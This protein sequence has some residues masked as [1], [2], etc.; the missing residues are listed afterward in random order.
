MKFYLPYTIETAAGTAMIALGIAYILITLG[1]TGLSSTAT[2]SY[3]IAGLAIACVGLMNIVLVYD[4][5]GRTTTV[6]NAAGVILFAAEIYLNLSPLAIVGLVLFAVAS[7]SSFLV[8]ERN[9]RTRIYPY[10]INI[11]KG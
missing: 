1:R 9:D 2:V 7:V 5:V 8:A 6:V 3:L 10:G 11:S 4:L